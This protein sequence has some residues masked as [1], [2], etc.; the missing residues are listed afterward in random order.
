MKKKTR[1]SDTISTDKDP[2]DCI[3]NDLRN[4]ME[5]TLLRGESNSALLL[6]PRGVGKT[7]LAHRAL[8]SF[9]RENGE[10]LGEGLEVFLHGLLQTDDRM[11]LKEIT[12]Q[13]MLENV[14]GDKVFGSFAEHL[15]FLLKSLQSGGRTKSKPIIFLLEEFDLF[16][17]H[18]NQTLLYNLFDV[19]QS[20][21]API[22]VI[23]LSCQLDVIERLEKRV[24]SRFSHRQLYMHNLDSFNDY[25]NIAQSILKARNIPVSTDEDFKKLLESIFSLRRDIGYLEQV[26]VFGHGFDKNDI[27]K[28]L[29]KSLNHM[30]V[31]YEASII[32]DLTLLEITLLI[33]S[34]HI[35][36]IYDGQSFNFEMVYHEFCKFVNRR[37]SNVL[38]YEKPTVSKA[39]ETLIAMELIIPSD[40]M[41]K[42]QKEYRLYSLQVTPEQIVSVIKNDRTMPVDIK[43][44][45]VSELH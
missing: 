19:A 41:S 38:K 5:T 22:C 7:R 28:G 16:A 15:E 37:T 26:L 30:N 36:F 2:Y 13:L 29:L 39:F 25:M 27:S 24:R 40:K 14:V 23:G 34:K 21:A 3:Y 44:W 10:I 1:K 6:G 45:A 4:L 35:Q 32:S 20:K 11:A 17:S 43:E 18:H 33:A 9:H 8:Q 12:K 42:T 31:E